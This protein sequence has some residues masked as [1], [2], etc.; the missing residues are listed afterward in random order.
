MNL[1][2][3]IRK[4]YT[5]LK[6]LFTEMNRVLVAYSGGIDSTLLLKIGTDQLGDNCVGAIAVSASLSK[7][8]HKEALVMGQSIGAHLFELK[9]MS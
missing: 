1:N 5:H 8:E 3:D 7:N 9:Q 2:S 4:K 6:N